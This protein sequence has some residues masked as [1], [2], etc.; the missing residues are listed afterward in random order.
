LFYVNF[1]TMLD[2]STVTGNSYAIIVIAKCPD[3]RIWDPSSDDH[4]IE[5]SQEKIDAYFILARYDIFFRPWLFQ[6]FGCAGSA[7]Y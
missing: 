7:G 6:C 4:R 5:I 3:E 1:F 2:S